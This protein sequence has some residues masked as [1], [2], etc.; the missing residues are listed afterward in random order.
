MRKGG[1]EPPRVLPHQILNLY[2]NRTKSYENLSNYLNLPG[3]SP[4]LFER[5]IQHRYDFNRDDSGTIRC[6]GNSQ[7][8]YRADWRAMHD[9]VGGALSRVNL[10]TGT[11]SRESPYCPMR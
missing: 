8:S 7:A 10:D 9:P 4:L 1:L 5:F 3:F 2:P 6:M 11:H